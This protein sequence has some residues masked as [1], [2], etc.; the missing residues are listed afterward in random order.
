MKKLSLSL[1]FG[2]LVPS[3]FAALVFADLGFNDVCVMVFAAVMNT[4]VLFNWTKG[5]LRCTRKCA[6][7]A[8]IWLCI[9]VAGNFIVTGQATTMIGFPIIYWTAVVAISK[10]RVAKC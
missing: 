2:G 3:I 9:I 5:L 1:L 6:A 4:F 7:L 8:A 10:R